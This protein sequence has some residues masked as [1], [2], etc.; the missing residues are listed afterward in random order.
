MKSNYLGINTILFFFLAIAIPKNTNGQDN[1]LNHGL[2]VNGW[3][4][5]TF[6]KPQA[7]TSKDKAPKKVGSVITVYND[8]KLNK[9]S[10]YISGINATTYTGN[11]L[12]D[13]K[14]LKLV[15]S[16]NPSIIRFPGGDASNA[17]FFNGIPTDL[18]SKSLTFNGEWT[19]FSDGTEDIDWKMNT[20]R[21]YAF[22]DSVK[23]EGFITVNYAYARYGKSANPVAKAAS[24]AADW[25]RFDKGRTKYWEV[26]NET[27]ACW[28]GGFK[29]DTILNKDGQPEYING[30]LYGKHFKIFADSM[31]AAAKEIGVEIYIG[32]VFADDDNV[33]DGSGK[34]VTKNWNDLLAP[35]LRRSNGDNY[36][37]FITVHSYFLND[38]KT[39]NEI[40]NSFKVPKELQEF[41]FGKLDKAKVKHVPLALTEWNI[42]APH[43][44][45]QVGG[46]QAVASSCKMQEI[47]F[48][49]SSYFCLKDY[50]RGDK[51]DF[52]IFS[53]HDSLLTNSEPY[54]SFYHLSYLNKI[55][56]DK[57]IKKQIVPDK[58][59][60]LCFASSYESGG[61]G[62]VIINKSATEQ[63]FQIDIPNYKIGDNYYW[64]ELSK[65]DDGNIWSE[66][67]AVNGVS[68]S[69]YS[70]GGPSES[71]EDI[72]AWTKDTKQGIKMKIKGLSAIYLL[73]E[74]KK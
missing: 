63:S 57:M 48:G 34:N 18:P 7:I 24:L 4:A 2:F 41:I 74:R 35:E 27:Y 62:M 28:E 12:V 15:S 46:L 50:W 47:G 26:G 55:I 51:G 36:A 53:H 65:Y 19:G 58:G 72:P 5:K 42:K 71:F 1:V 21:Y 49:A 32:A 17:Y 44:T 39:P 25:V 37:D 60:L 64:Y 38:E 52:G 73:I 33:W 31:R 23:S 13:N 10:R 29:I 22:L 56:G 8:V 43:Q 69:K 70:K 3:E 11:Y 16:L 30:K 9:V 20:A 61:I 59:D 6:K 67:L 45:S 54:P 68:N 14:F 66:K 40:I